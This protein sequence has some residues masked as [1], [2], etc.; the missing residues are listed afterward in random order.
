M[1]GGGH[2]EG[3][4]GHHCGAGR[5]YRGAYSK[6][7]HNHWCSFLRAVS[8][9]CRNWLG[10]RMGGTEPGQIIERSMAIPDRGSNL[11][12][13]SPTGASLKL[14]ISQKSLILRS[15][16]DPRFTNYVQSSRERMP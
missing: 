5:G 14:R 11:Y 6:T 16:S 9:Y 15:A 8:G 3:E 10:S 7:V 1:R 2:G 13:L 4:R 12:F